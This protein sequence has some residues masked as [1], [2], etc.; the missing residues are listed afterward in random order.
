[1]A[2]TSDCSDVIQLDS[3]LKFAKQKDIGWLAWSWDRDNCAARQVST[4]GLFASLSPYGNLIVNNAQFG[5]ANTAV[6]MLVPN[7]S[8]LQLNQIQLAHSFFNQQHFLKWNIPFIFQNAYL[9]VS[10]N[11]IDFVKNSSIDQQGNTQQVQPS[12]T[13]TFYQLQVLDANNQV[14]KSNI[15]S[16]DGNQQHIELVQDQ[17][18]NE[19]I[20]KGALPNSEIRIMNTNGNIVAQ[21]NRIEMNTKIQMSNWAAGVY[22][23]YV[24]TSD[25]V[26]RLKLIKN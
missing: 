23:V 21:F 18:T 10:E 15:V 9:Y 13:K 24:F 2:N 20:I 16:I 11:G 8:P 4:N 6:K 17:N 12:N 14:Q 7:N 5:L 3:L 26:V 19:L 22:F 1:V 25:D